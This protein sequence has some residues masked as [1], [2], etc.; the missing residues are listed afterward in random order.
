[1]TLPGFAII[2]RNRLVISRFAEKGDE[3]D[4]LIKILLVV[5]SL[6]QYFDTT[7][8]KTF[9][10]ELASSVLSSLFFVAFSCYYKAIPVNN[11]KTC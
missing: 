2:H 5:H 11:T 9:I 7:A 10:G 8:K 6:Q 1:M 4:F 3:V